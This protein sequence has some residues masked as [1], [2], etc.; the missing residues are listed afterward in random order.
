[1]RLVRVID[2]EAD[3]SYIHTVHTGGVCMYVE[4]ICL[5]RLTDVRYIPDVGAYIE[6]VD[7]IECQG[8]VRL[9][10]SGTNLLLGAPGVDTWGTG[11]DT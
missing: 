3:L 10:A 7:A 4:W 5:P 9:D 6:C 8:G 1:M 11:E 2:N